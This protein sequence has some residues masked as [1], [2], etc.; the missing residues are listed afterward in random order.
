M[1]DGQEST[2]A[3]QNVRHFGTEGRRGGI[4]E[5]PPSSDLYEFIIFRGGDIKDLKV[6]ETRPQAQPPPVQMPPDPAIVQAPAHFGP[7]LSH[8][9][10]PYNFPYIAN[11]NPF[12]SSGGMQHAPRYT[13]VGPPP[14]TSG[15]IQ[16]GIMSA[17]PTHLAGQHDGGPS[18][19]ARFGSIHTPG[20]ETLAAAQDPA[21][22]AAPQEPP[23]STV[24]SGSTRGQRQDSVSRSWGPPPVRTSP[25][26]T[27][28]TGPAPSKQIPSSNGKPWDQEKGHGQ[29]AAVASKPELRAPATT[30]STVESANVGDS[31]SSGD[32]ART[33]EVRDPSVTPRRMPPSGREVP[34]NR[35]RSRTGP[36]ALRTRGP[37]LT[38]PAEDFDFI[39][40]NEKFDKASIAETDSAEGVM[41]KVERK[42][43]K[44]SSFFDNITTEKDVSSSNQPRRNTDMETFGETAM[45]RNRFR[46]GR[47][48]RGRGGYSSMRGRGGSYHGSYS[49]N[50]AGRPSGNSNGSGG[51]W[52][53]HPVVS[54][55]M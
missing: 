41:P 44:S 12:D 28:H 18:E 7:T 21:L 49:G 19:G 39:A 10:I 22:P 4:D 53:S 33:T 32:Q 36:P 23:K 45:G 46:G 54:R 14:S 8:P 35:G 40:M 52:G 3:L 55:P 1:T 9:Q 2:V 16:G 24:Q 50:N 26:T 15:A 17:V 38:L 6:L 51:A 37:G 11:Q 43:D 27:A 13:P 42:Y 48:G 47:G 34:P 30:T 20:M 29:S 25:P 31:Q 5:I